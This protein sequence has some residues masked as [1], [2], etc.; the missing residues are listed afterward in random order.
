[1]KKFQGMTLKQAF[2]Y[3]RSW[4]NE[5]RSKYENT[6]LRVQQLGGELTDANARI[7]V[8]KHES[9]KAKKRARQHWI[10]RNEVELENTRLQKEQQTHLEQIKTLEKE[11]IVLTDKLLSSRGQTFQELEQIIAE[12]AARIGLLSKNNSP[13]LQ[14][15]DVDVQEQTKVCKLKTDDLAGCKQKLPVTE[16]WKGAALCKNCAKKRRKKKRR[17]II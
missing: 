7:R 17:K 5:F 6:L 3:E 12:Q 14:E 10:R 9:S 11:K 2:E 16:F 15:A 8:L 4:A 1:M 13:N